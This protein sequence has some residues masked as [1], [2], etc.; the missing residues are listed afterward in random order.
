MAKDSES[1][2]LLDDELYNSLK[3]YMTVQVEKPKAKLQRVVKKLGMKAFSS[4][5]LAAARA[6]SPEDGENKEEEEY[7]LEVLPD[8]IVQSVDRW[9]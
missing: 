6:S 3:N 9:R 7:A 4:K 5:L 8:Y 1:G 2:Y